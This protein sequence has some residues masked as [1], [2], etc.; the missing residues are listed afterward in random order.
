MGVMI[1]VPT[2]AHG[3]EIGQPT[4]AAQIMPEIIGAVSMTVRQHYDRTGAV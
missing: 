4:V 3:K 2:F 1:V